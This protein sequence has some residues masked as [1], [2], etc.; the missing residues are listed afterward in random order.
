MSWLFLCL[1]SAL[2]MGSVF[3]YFN[4]SQLSSFLTNY[5]VTVLVYCSFSSVFFFFLW[6][7]SSFHRSFSIIPSFIH[8]P[9]YAVI[10][11]FMGFACPLSGQEFEWPT[12]CLFLKVQRGVSNRLDCCGDIWW[13]WWFKSNQIHEWPSFAWGSLGCCCAAERGRIMSA[14]H[15]IASLLVVQEFIH[16]RQTLLMQKMSSHSTL[17][18][19]PKLLYP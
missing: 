19:P 18:T 3:S 12:A 2:S 13:K 4:I 6:F 1:A 5:P 15:H 16:D 8:S 7:C 14:A 10:L 11:W 9:C 17:S